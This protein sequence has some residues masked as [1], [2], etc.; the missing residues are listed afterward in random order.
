M[1][2]PIVD[3]AGQPAPPAPSTAAQRGGTSTGAAAA[4]VS[5]ARERTLPGP[6]HR[7]LLEVRVAEGIQDV[8]AAAHAV[9]AGFSGFPAETSYRPASLTADQAARAGAHHE[10]LMIAGR[11]AEAFAR[12]LEQQ[13]NVT[14]AWFEI[15]AKAAGAASAPAVA[16]PIRSRGQARRAAASRWRRAGRVSSRS[17]RRPRCGVQ[18]GCNQDRLGGRHLDRRHQR[19][20][21]RR[22]EG[23][24]SPVSAALLVR[25]GATGRRSPSSTPSSG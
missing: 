17:A 4:G 20:R 13:P 11:V 1:S 9:V 5:A 15:P 2:D 14:R 19:R 24:R 10:L 7:V 22:S 21:D 25:A 3:H 12:D 16:G 6:S 18:A 23:R 8:A